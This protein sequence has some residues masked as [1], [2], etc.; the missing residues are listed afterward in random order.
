MSSIETKSMTPI[1]TVDELLSEFLEAHPSKQHGILQRLAIPA[2]NF[3]P[4]ATCDPGSYTRNCI[5]RTEHA[6]FILLCW[7][8]GAKTKIHDHH[9][10]NCWIFQVKGSIVESRYEEN[11]GSLDL[12]NEAV[13]EEGS[14]S[15]MHD[16]MGYHALENRSNKKGMTLH[17]YVNP[18][19]QCKVY[20]EASGLMEVQELEYDSNHELMVA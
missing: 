1:T 9:G 8:P 6:E 3:E 12:S 20:N 17:I 7:D 11:S 2:E 19:D 15:F 16:T 18:I 4:Y 14:I 13:M 10:Q 5:A